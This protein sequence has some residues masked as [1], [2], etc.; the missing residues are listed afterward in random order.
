M[1]RS[2]G[3]SDGR[4]GR[5][6]SG[7][8]RSLALDLRQSARPLESANDLDPLLERIGDA[9]YVLL[10]EASEED[11]VPF[12]GEQAHKA[13]ALAVGLHALV[14]ALAGGDGYGAVLLVAHPEADP[15]PGLRDLAAGARLPGDAN[16]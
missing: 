11:V 7:K 9:R 12:G 6:E 2:G 4:A 5:D 8:I 16:G 13:F 3:R 15:I 14:D 10:G 1:F